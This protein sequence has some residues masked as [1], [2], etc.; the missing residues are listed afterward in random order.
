MKPSILWLSDSPTV[1][2]GYGIVTKN[3]IGRLSKLGYKISVIGFQ[4]S[5][6]A[7]IGDVK[8]YPIGKEPYGKD[9][10]QKYLDDIK[11]DILITLGDLFF[12]NY[13]KNINFKDTRW[14]PYYPIDGDS[15]PEQ[16]KE[17]LLSANKRIA[18]C[19]Y[20]ANLTREIN[21]DCEMVY[22]GVDTNVFKPLNK[23]EIKQKYGLSDKFI[24]GC[25]ARNQPRKMLPRLLKVFKI[26]SKDKKDAILYLHTT[27][28]YPKGH[29]LVA[30]THKLNLKER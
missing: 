14:M 17:I 21:I 28:L 20:A 25:V 30:L 6:E 15:I 4:S 18:M 5:N 22:L 9:V 19:N 26:F 23:Q 27:P 8:I 24:I 2:T 3:I 16:F 13:F 1:C 11:P 12:F 29:N 10:L 7:N